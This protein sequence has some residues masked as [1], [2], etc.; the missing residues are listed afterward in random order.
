VLPESMAAVLLTGHGGLEKLEYRTDVPTPSPGPGEVLIQVAAA[1]I[2]NTDVNTRIGWYSKTVTSKTGEGGSAGFDAVDVVDAAWSGTAMAFPRIQGADVCGLIVEVGEGVSH[3]RVG[4]RVVVRNMLRTPT[5]YRPFECWTFGS[6]CDGGFA[7]FA[8]APSRETYAVT[9]DWLDA[10]LAAVPCAYSTA[11]NMMQRAAVGSERV[12]VTGASGGVG[13]AA[14]Q[15]AK[16]RGAEV[17]AV[18]SGSKAAEVR[19]QG[20]DQTLDRSADLVANLGRGAIDVV[21][22]VVGG[23]QASQVLDL[24]RRGGRYAIAGAIAGPVAELD[25]RTVYLKDLSLLGCTFQEDEVFES[26]ISYIEGAEIRPVVARTYPL[27]ELARAQQ[28]FLT[29]GHVGKLVVIPPRGD[30]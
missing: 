28:D 12:L 18:C 3:G 6:E 9:S 16:R 19:A 10:E 14:V 24:L 22:D 2:N 23:P 30:A 4:E 17:V 25:L 8:V 7:Q 15:L 29:K 27:S 11:E 13:L 21:I 1:A 20:A 5:E 26:L